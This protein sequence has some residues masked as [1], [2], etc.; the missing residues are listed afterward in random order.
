MR[1]VAETLTVLLVS[2]KLI[3]NEDDVLLLPSGRKVRS[4]FGPVTLKLFGK[5]SQTRMSLSSLP[6]AA[7]LPA[8]EP[9]SLTILMGCLCFIASDR[10]KLSAATRSLV[11]DATRLLRNRSV[12]EGAAMVTKIPRMATVTI[13]S[14]NVKP[15]CLLRAPKT[16]TG[17]PR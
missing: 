2:P 6:L 1:P 8:Q 12:K 14:I 17:L 10:A 13:A 4:P 3:T 15:I 5:L 9:S 11:A 7:H 16:F